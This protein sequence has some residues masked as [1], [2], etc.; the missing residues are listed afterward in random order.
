MDGNFSKL[1]TTA[2][3]SL[4]LWS[5]IT[6]DGPEP[7]AKGNE[8]GEGGKVL[9]EAD[10]KKKWVQEDLM[11]LSVLQGSLETLQKTFGNVSNLSR[12]FELKK[13]I[14]SLMQDGMDLIKHIGK[15]R[16]LLS[17]L[18]NLRPDTSDH[19]ILVERREYDKMFGLMMTFDTCYKDV[20]KHILRSPSLPTMEEVCAQ[21]QKEEESLGLFGRK[22]ELLMSHQADDMQANKAAYK[23]EGRK[24]GERFEG[25]CD[26]CKKPRHK[27]SQ[28]WILHPHLKPSKFKKDR[29]AH[30]HLSAEAS[31][32][33]STGASACVQAVESEGRNLASHHLSGKSLEHE[34]IRKS[35]IDALIK[36]LKESGNKLGNTF[37]YSF[38][39]HTM[40]SSTDKFLDM[41]ESSYTAKAESSIANKLIGLFENLKNKNDHRRTHIAKNMHKPLI[42]DYGAS[43]H[44]ISDN[45]LI[46]YIEPAQGHVMIAN[47]DR[48]PIRGIGRLKLFNK[49]SKAFFMPEFTSNL[50]SDNGGEYTGHAFKDHLTSHGILHQTSCSYTPQQN[51]VAERKNRHL[52]EVARSMMFHTSVHKR[53]WSDDVMSACYLINRIPTKILADQSPFE[54]LNK[55]K[56]ALEHLRIFGCVCYVLVLGEMRNKLVAKSTKAMLIEKNWEELGDLSQPSD[57]AAS[58]RN[59]LQGLGIGVSQDQIRRQK[60]IRVIA[61]ESSHF[62]HE[63]ESESEAASLEDQDSDEAE[64]Q[65]DQGSDSPVQSGEDSRRRDQNESQEASEESQIQDEAVEKAAVEHPSQAVCSFAEYPEDHYAF[66]VSLDESYVPRS[67]EEAMLIQEWR[68]SVNAKADDMIRND[69]W[70]E[71]KLP[72][73]KRAVSCKWIFTIKY[74]PNGK[75]DMCKTR[76]VARGFT[77][78]YGEDYIDIFAPV[79]KLHTIRIVLSVATNLG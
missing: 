13:V 3:G 24:Y 28:C 74:L 59:I 17:E 57:K 79:A 77:Q 42:I 10:V 15:F 16:A 20:I 36:A 52:I 43:H 31:G 55:S 21:L 33:G 69:T 46:K 62:E 76:L 44:M 37:G 64:G 70:Y 26:H 39:A 54:V 60:P 67:Y 25:S 58:L 47:G 53:Y 35:D 45:S 50:L 11:V 48:I 61:E 38:A 66:M 27:K 72:K 7:V 78:T 32:S 23:N 71:N 30:A 75:I 6:D 5:H 51:G 73:G 41:L 56:P 68:D 9:T 19:E 1:V 34:V 40:P 4:G 2:V 22:E 12:V 14:T 63:G 49:D 29:E 18:D 8:E 65:R